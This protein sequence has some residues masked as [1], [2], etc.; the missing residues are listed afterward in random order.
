MKQTFIKNC[1]KYLYVK[2]IN[3][4]IIYYNLIQYVFNAKFSFGQIPFSNNQHSW[5][6]DWN[7]NGIIA[8]VLTQG[9]MNTML[10]CKWIMTFTGIQIR[11]GFTLCK[12]LSSYTTEQN[13]KWNVCSNRPLFFFSTTLSYAFLELRKQFQISF[14]A[15]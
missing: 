9:Y 7:I 4:I 13:D 15:I 8:D 10:K 14:G 1:P 2:Y 6:K 11:Q 5:F 12:D 3:S